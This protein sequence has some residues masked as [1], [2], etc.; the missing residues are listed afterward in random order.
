MID[1]QISMLSQAQRDRLAYLE[2][3]L[4]FFG[5]FRRQE[6]VARFDIKSAA[7]T[8]DLASYKALVP[9]NL[10]YDS[11]A[12][13]YIRSKSFIPL[14]NFSVE[15]VLLWL[16]RGLADC[17]PSSVRPVISSEDT[18]LSTL[19][20]LENLSII[21]R[22]IYKRNSVEISY[23]SIASGFST[24]EIIPFAL[25]QAGGRWFVRAF[26]RRINSFKCF[27]INRIVDAKFLGESPKDLESP[28]NDIQWNR[29]VEIELVPHPANIMHPDAIE[30]EYG[31]T[32]GV[33]Y[34]TIRA[35]MVGYFLRALNVDCT[36]DHSL[37]GIEYHL[38]LRNRQ[39][40][41]GV[42]N[43][44]LAL[45]YDAKDGINV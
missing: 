37:R 10:E 44:V 32:S 31:M 19:L 30:T 38:W 34:K 7:A 41:Y 40:L 17:E 23:R 39:A 2:L 26:D 33:L 15:R 22:A 42:E 21:T 1:L 27:V 25:A 13:L 43:L 18:E 4:W 35:S 3:R 5:E 9:R 6:L 24:R 36:S 28:E 20:S 14:F 8:R 16:T 11:S 45:G 29:K 12:K